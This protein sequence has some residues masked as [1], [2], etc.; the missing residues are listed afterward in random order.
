MLEKTVFFRAQSNAGLLPQSSAEVILS[1]RSNVGK[2]SVIN[3]LCSQKN[4]A[5]TSKTPG[6]TRSINVYSVVM[7]KWIIDLPGYGFAKVSHQ[8][9]ELWN[10]MI[11]DCIIF[12]KSKKIVYIIVDAFVGPTEL[13]FSMAA[14]LNDH[15]IHFKVIANKCD[16]LPGDIS[17]DE[18]QDKIAQYFAIDKAD[19]FVVSAKNKQRFDKLKIDIVKFLSC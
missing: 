5:R 14:W 3:T 6:R 1:G 4:L 8:E 18:I 12:R 10:R 15:N 19:T 7:K 16:K 2:S 17:Q 13:D 9:K 11:E